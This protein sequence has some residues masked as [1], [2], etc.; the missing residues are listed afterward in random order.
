MTDK[1]PSPAS[2]PPQKP[3]PPVVPP[4]RPPLGPPPPA[5]PGLVSTG[6]KGQD[7]QT[8]KTR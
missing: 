8:I 1:K 2:P 6:K 3:N 4:K 5:D 7:P